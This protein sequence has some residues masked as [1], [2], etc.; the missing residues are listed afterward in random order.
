VAS[1]TKVEADALSANGK[2]AG[3][4]RE[5]VKQSDVPAYSLTDALRVAEALRDEYAKQPTKPIDVARV[6]NY[7]PGAG[8]FKMLTGAAVA[9]GIT[10]GGAQADMIG[11]TDLGRR[12]VAPTEE[13]DDVLAMHEALLKPR[14]VNEFLTKY[15]ESPL[16]SQAVAFNVLEQMG[17]PA[18][19]LER[20]HELIVTGAERLGLLV[21]IKSKRYVR[22]D[23]APGAIDISG[24]GAATID[25]IADPDGDDTYVEDEAPRVPAVA[26]AIP[27]TA[28]NNK[29]F[30]THGKNKAVVAQIKEIL[31]YGKFEPVV[32]VERETTA[33]PV[34][35]KVM[36]DMRG[37]YAAVVHVGAEQVFIDDKGEEHRVLNPNVL[38]EIGAAMALFRRRFVLLV[39]KGVSLPSN[40][41]GLY[42]VRYE[43][44]GLDHEATMKLL[45]S[46]NE[47]R[48]KE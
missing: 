37:C 9:Y 19:A 25:E 6:L 3:K 39:E 21:E 26:P 46:F 14:V 24:N 42:E 48:D 2:T 32:S 7:A 28:S 38:I 35:D 15:N 23:A 20:T 33:K 29:V 11:L 45:K 4:R 40:L 10:D 13:G 41:Q 34:P 5:R 44:D 1:R 8:P 22:L 30:I 16:P 36:D 18:H 27:E 12:I 47:F 31:L 17:V 43:G